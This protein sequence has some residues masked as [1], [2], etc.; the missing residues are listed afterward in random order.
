MLLG[1]DRQFFGRAT[2]QLVRGEVQ[3]RQAVGFTV[4]LPPLSYL[5]HDR[6]NHGSELVFY[7]LS[8]SH[9]GG[10]VP[11]LIAPIRGY[12]YHIHIV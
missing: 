8:N 5:P 6:E 7:H 9:T 1:A 10:R 12:D 3:L 4:I 2:V 11:E